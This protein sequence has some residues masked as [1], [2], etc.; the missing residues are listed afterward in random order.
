MKAQRNLRNCG[1]CA[2]NCA[3]PTSV[4]LIQDG[5]NAALCLGHGLN[6]HIQAGAVC[7]V[8]GQNP[9]LT[10]ANGGL[11]ALEAL[12]QRPQRSKIFHFFA[13]KT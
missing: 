5:G 10:E 13:K 2:S 6:G 9:Q 12:G 11:G 3:L 8:W 7:E 4:R 1:G